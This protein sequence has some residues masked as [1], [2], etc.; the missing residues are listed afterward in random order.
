MENVLSANGQQL[1]NNHNHFD[2]SSQVKLSDEKSQKLYLPN[3]YS[4]AAAAAYARWERRLVQSSFH[5]SYSQHSFTEASI[6]CASLSSSDLLFHFA[7]FFSSSAPFLPTFQNVCAVRLPVHTRASAASML[8]SYEWVTA[9]GSGEL[10]LKIHSYWRLQ[11]KRS[12][13]KKSTTENISRFRCFFFIL[14]CGNPLHFSLQVEPG[15]PLCWFN[16]LKSFEYMYW[17]HG[18]MQL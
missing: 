18:K 11:H 7:S 13:K 5:F 15:L 17:N 3:Y 16:S 1:P 10:H 12:A 6:V 8:G 2:A 14:C 4:T 9:R